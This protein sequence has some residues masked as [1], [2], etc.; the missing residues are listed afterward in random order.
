[1]TRFSLMFMVACV[2]ATAAAASDE[3]S[4]GDTANS[5]GLRVVQSGKRS[6]D[7][8]VLDSWTGLVPAAATT[9]VI[10]PIGR[11]AHV[12][13]IDARALSSWAGSIPSAADATI[14]PAER[15]SGGVLVNDGLQLL[16]SWDGSIRAASAP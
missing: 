5:P 16:A 4:A 13:S 1:M 7:R 12:P 2:I 8:V 15:E 11:G 10:A 6:S 14:A 9:R 3:M